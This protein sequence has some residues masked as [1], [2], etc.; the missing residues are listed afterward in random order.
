MTMIIPSRWFAGGKGLDDFRKNMLNDQRIRK[1]VDYENYKDVFPS[2]GG[3]A[4]GACY[5]L[6]DRDHTGKCEVTNKTSDSEMNIM[7][8]FAAV[9]RS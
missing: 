1:I 2:L 9:D 4:G 6:W 7:G 5:F 3:L 8:H